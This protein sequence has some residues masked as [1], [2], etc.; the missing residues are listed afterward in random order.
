MKPGKARKAATKLGMLGNLLRKW[1]LE[2]KANKEV[3]DRK[4]MPENEQKSESTDLTTTTKHLNQKESIV[5]VPGPRTNFLPG[6]AEGKRLL[7]G[8]VKY[9]L[10]K[11]D[12]QSIDQLM[13]KRRWPRKQL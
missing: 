2:G 6:N 13:W 11:Y 4:R 7:G 9:K 8:A 10:E 3:F 1:L 5:T 12:I